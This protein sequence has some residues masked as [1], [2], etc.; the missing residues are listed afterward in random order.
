M[1]KLGKTV[2]QKVSILTG[3]DLKKRYQGQ[4]DFFKN[5]LGEMGVVKQ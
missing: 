4:Y 5:I 3:D 1:D 2:Q